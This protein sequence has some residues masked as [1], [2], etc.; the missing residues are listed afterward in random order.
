MQPPP[1]APYQP[2]LAN[3][4][5]SDDPFVPPP[6]PPARFTLNITLDPAYAS[7]NCSDCAPPAP[8]GVADG[9]HRARDAA[10]ARVPPAPLDRYGSPT[11]GDCTA[12]GLRLRGVAE[13]VRE[14]R[15]CAR[16]LRMQVLQHASAHNGVS[17]FPT[18]ARC[19]RP[20][21]AARAQPR[22]AC[23]CPIRRRVVPSET[24]R[25]TWFRG[26]LHRPVP[27]AAM[28]VLQHASAHHGASPFPQVRFTVQFQRPSTCAMLPG[29]APDDRAVRL[30]ESDCVWLQMIAD[31]C[32]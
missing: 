1:P 10:R 6:A 9:F 17:P 26:A 3:E 19:R 20:A 24:S 28:Q 29:P 2:S 18:G 30:C 13:L 15:C 12:C 27:T 25:A 23:T 7:F 16:Q 31:D 5:L 21:A 22:A 32:V 4:S 8:P 14:C 11:L